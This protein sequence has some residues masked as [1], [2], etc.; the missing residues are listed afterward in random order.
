MSIKSS[1]RARKL[2]TDGLRNRD[3]LLAAAKAAFAELGADVPPGDVARRAGVGIGTLYRHFPTRDELVAA[4]YERDVEQLTEAADALLGEHRAEEALAL[5]LG[6]VI[7]YVAEKRVIALAL[8]TYTG[9][10]AQIHASSEATLSAALRRLVD[11][12][13]AAGT[14]RPEIGFD[15]VARMMAGI[16]SGSDQPDWKGSAR[17][18]LD[19]M[20]AGL[21][22]TP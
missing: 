14:I 7:E 13:Q 17:R 15:D 12:A 18:L 9:A 16:C 19:V 1:P 8:R 5:W 11:A 22:A 6:Q 20:M 4:V 21:R 2:R 10:G 3:L